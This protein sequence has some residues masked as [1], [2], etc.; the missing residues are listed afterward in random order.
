MSSSPTPKSIAEAKAIYEETIAKNKAD[1]DKRAAEQRLIEQVERA[2]YSAECRLER[3]KQ[4]QRDDYIYSL[5]PAT[6]LMDSIATSLEDPSNDASNLICDH[7]A[8]TGSDDNI[9]IYGI[10]SNYGGNQ[11]NGIYNFY[12]TVN[13]T[14]D[15]TWQEL[16]KDF[17]RTGTITRYINNGQFSGYKLVGYG[18][19]SLFLRWILSDHRTFHVYL[20][21]TLWTK[22]FGRF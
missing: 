18:T 12:K 14:V 4:Q 10:R 20:R 1:S 22:W 9:Y 11:F 21:K 17:V 8:K 2:K 13:T 5:K 16:A 15:C 6:D 3:E 19:N 7:I